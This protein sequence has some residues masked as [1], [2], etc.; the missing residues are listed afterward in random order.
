MNHMATATHVNNAE[1]TRVCRVVAF[2]L[3][4]SLSSCKTAISDDD[5]R[6]E[7]RLFTEEWR[8]PTNDAGNCVYIQLRVLGRKVDYAT[9]HGMFRDGSDHPSLVSIRDA[10]RRFGLDTR[11]VRCAPTELARMPMPVIT[12]LHGDREGGGFAII[13]HVG[14]DRCGLVIGATAT[15]EEVSI[16]RFRRDWCGLVV[17]P[18]T[19]TNQRRPAFFASLILLGV[20]GCFLGTFWGLGARTLVGH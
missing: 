11:I 9:V 15:L 1:H 13:H 3:V 10:L 17:A 18:Q 20:Y 19:T 8:S 5:V 2:V 4:I 16:D 6:H 14:E 12:Y 7:I